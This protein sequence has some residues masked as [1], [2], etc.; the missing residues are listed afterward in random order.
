LE[1]KGVEMEEGSEEN[2]INI[3]DKQVFSIS[4]LPSGIILR[5]IIKRTNNFLNMLSPEYDLYLANGL[6]H[7]LS[8]KKYPLRN[9]ELFKFSTN[10]IRFS[11]PNLLSIMHANVNHNVYWMLNLP[12]KIGEHELSIVDLVIGYYKL[13]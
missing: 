7:I 3:V 6:K 4:K 8:A 12:K 11:E 5:C 13:K 1:I 2:V 9:R 10:P